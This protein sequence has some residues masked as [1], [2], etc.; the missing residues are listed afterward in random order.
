MAVL[1]TN[2]V[3]TLLDLAKMHNQKQL[4]D[5]AQVLDK[6]NGLFRTA[7]WT[8]A[9][10]LASHVFT[11][12]VALPSGN[13]RGVNEGIAADSAQNEQDVEA[14][15]R[16]E[17]RNEIDEYLLDIEPKPKEFRYKKDM[18]NMRGYIQ[19]VCDAFLYGNP[20]TTIGKPRG[21]ATRFATL[22]PTPDNVQTAGSAA[23]AAVTS[24]WICQWGPGRMSL[25]YPREKMA[26]LVK[27]EDMGRTY[28]ITDTTNNKGLFK[29][30]T[31]FYSVFGILVEDKRSTQRICNVGTTG[32]NEVDIDQ[33]LWALDSLPDPEDTSGAVIYV[34]RLTRFQISKALR[35][36]P[37][38][39]STTVDEYGRQVDRLRGV[40]LVLLENIKLT[41]TVVA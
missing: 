11:R 33:V 28:V 3:A 10:Q 1:T 38:L 22:S 25:L 41:E 37:N 20:A 24:V 2:T 23:A 40:P 19:A 18:Q 26:D 9:N 21:L 36:R 17:G 32:A 34:N 16:V 39:Y 7:S 14:L 12:E 29:Y 13:W 8:E 4:L 30:I 27:M 15:G 31:R 5:I 6:K 35:N